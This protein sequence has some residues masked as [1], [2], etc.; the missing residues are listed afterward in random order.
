MVSNTAVGSLD[1]GG[2]SVR[3]ELTAAGL[4]ANDALSI[5][6]V[7]HKVRVGDLDGL[8]TEGEID[9]TGL[10][11]DTA[12]NDVVVGRGVETSGGEAGS[13]GGV[14]ILGEVAKGSTA[15]EDDGQRGRRGR[16]AGESDR[17]QSDPVSAGQVS[18]GES[19]RGGGRGG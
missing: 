17:V 7:P 5:S 14:H 3:K 1:S 2:G 16:G 6:V 15:V 9:G 12:V 18:M 19:T 4:G 10:V 13:D 11:L 8:S